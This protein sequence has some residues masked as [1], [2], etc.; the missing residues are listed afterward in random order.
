MALEARLV[1]ASRMMEA[2]RRAASNGTEGAVVPGFEK[3]GSALFGSL[4]AYKY[5]AGG[6][7]SS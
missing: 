2:R 1:G 5:T 4:P 6:D 3:A 7:S